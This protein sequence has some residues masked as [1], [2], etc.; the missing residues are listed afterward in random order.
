MAIIIVCGLTSFLVF[1]ILLHSASRLKLDTGMGRIG[2]AGTK[3]DIREVVRMS[4][5]PGIKLE[6]LFSHMAC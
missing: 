6:G 4:A 5:L 2:Y 3:E 1:I